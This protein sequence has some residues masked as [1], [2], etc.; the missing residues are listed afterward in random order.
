L[1]VKGVFGISLI[2]IS[3]S[4]KVTG[5]NI[6]KGDIGWSERSGETVL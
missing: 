5:S 3:K 6:D 2:E 1:L 4:I